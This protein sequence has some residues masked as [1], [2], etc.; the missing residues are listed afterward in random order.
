MGFVFFGTLARLG[1]AELLRK[2]LDKHLMTLVSYMLKG[3][4]RL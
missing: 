1:T 2:R 4:F 3:E